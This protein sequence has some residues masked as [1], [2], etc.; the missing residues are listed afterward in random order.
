MVKRRLFG[1]I[2]ASKNNPAYFDSI[3]VTSPY[4]VA[5]LSGDGIKLPCPWRKLATAAT[6]R[7]KSA[8]FRVFIDA[9]ENVAKSLR[10]SH[11]PSVQR[12]PGVV[13][14]AGFEPATPTVSR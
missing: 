10:P 2:R 6:F 9:D 14:G 5:N 12:V 8:Y 7:H 3:D 13:R 11:F 4:S 1:C